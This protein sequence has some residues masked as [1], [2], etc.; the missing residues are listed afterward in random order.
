MRR[1]DGKPFLAQRHGITGQGLLVKR[2]ILPGSAVYE[3]HAAV[4]AAA[5]G[6]DPGDTRGDESRQ[7]LGHK[8]LEMRQTDLAVPV[9][10]DRTR[11]GGFSNAQSR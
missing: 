6:K 2:V 11:D 3:Q 5:D 8:L 1:A 7:Q 4:H 9:G 10:D